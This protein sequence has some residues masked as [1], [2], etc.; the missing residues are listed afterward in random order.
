MKRAKV[1]YGASTGETKSIRKKIRIEIWK[2]ILS[3]NLYEAR[4]EIL[5]LKTYDRLKITKRMGF[6]FTFGTFLLIF[7]V[8]FKK[9]QNSKLHTRGELSKHDF[10]NK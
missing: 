4:F 3:I 6:C 8:K 9:S 10:G 2:I 1:A 7:R 5:I